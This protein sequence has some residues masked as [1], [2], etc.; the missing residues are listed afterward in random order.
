MCCITHP[1]KGLNMININYKA[2][3]YLYLY[4]HN[5]EEI[6]VNR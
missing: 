3:P 5:D 6:N 2:C 4:L 1:V